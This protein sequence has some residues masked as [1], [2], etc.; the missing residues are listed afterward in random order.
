MAYPVPVTGQAIKATSN[1]ASGIF[2]FARCARTDTTATDAFIVPPHLT[3]SHLTVQSLG[4]LSDAGTSAV[5]QLIEKTGSTVIASIDVK[6]SKYGFSAVDIS[7]QI[8][9]SKLD[10][11]IQVRYVETGTPSTSGGPWLVSL[12]T[13]S[14]YGSN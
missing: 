6:T 1:T 3:P 13:M 10:A 12:E 4:P 9:S 11:P 8:F 5:V 14:N 7:P 2:K